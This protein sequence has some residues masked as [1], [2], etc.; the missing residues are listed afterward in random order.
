MSSEALPNYYYLP[1]GSDNERNL[2][3]GRHEVTSFRFGVSLGIN[4]I[5]VGLC[6]LFGVLLGIRG[7]GSSCLDTVGL[8]LVAFR[9]VE[10][11]QLGVSSLLL[12]NILWDTLCPK[13]KH[14]R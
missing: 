6:V 4:L 11:H 13:T 8:S 1:S 10:C 7:G 12:E 3:L 2:G 9:L 14:A 5:L